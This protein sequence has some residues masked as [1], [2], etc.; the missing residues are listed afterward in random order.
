MVLAYTG[1][2]PS[3]LAI[4]PYYDKLGHVI[5]YGLAAYLG[6]RLLHPFTLRLGRYRL[7]L[8]VLAFSGWTLAEE[9]AQF[10]APTRSLDALDLVCSVLGILVGYWLARHQLSQHSGASQPV[11]KR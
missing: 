2:L 3:Q 9:G 11:S 5:L 4:I 10:F 8:W 1:N 6:H 7:P